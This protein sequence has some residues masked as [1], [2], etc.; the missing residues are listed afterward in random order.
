[1]PQY[2]YPS[3]ERKRGNVVHA[4]VAS[5]NRN[6]K[7]F[8]FNHLLPKTLNPYRVTDGAVSKGHKDNGNFVENTF[9]LVE[10]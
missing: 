6:F 4:V 7:L 2:H 8:K 1:M 9:G 3:K 5:K 10:H